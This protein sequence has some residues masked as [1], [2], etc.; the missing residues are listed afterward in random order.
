[1]TKDELLAIKARAEAATR[2]PWEDDNGYRVYADDGSLCIVE[3]KHLDGTPADNAF[4]AHART[5]V[6]ALV[7]EIRRLRALCGRA[8]DK[9]D[10]YWDDGPAGEG[11]QSKELQA[12]V[13]ELWTARDGDE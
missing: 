6:P 12:L 9:L 1:M 10:E 3:T 7:E 13:G 8:A 11:W 5:D 2:G 4:I